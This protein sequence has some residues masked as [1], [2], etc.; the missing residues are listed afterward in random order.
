MASVAR[1]MAATV[2]MAGTLGGCER[3]NDARN[4]RKANL[5]D[6]NH[7]TFEN[8]RR[9]TTRNLTPVGNMIT[10]GIECS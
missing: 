10:K 3:Q 7:A 1:D 9:R 4:E 5:V 8:R 2:V 6:L